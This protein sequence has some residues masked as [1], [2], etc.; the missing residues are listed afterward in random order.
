MEELFRHSL[1]YAIAKG[2]PEWFIDLRKEALTFY[3][4]ANW[5]IYERF[6][7]KEWDLTEVRL[8][9]MPV[10]QWPETPILTNEEN[11][12]LSVRVGNDSVAIQLDEEWSRKGV[13]VEDLWTALHDHE[14]LV[15]EAMYQLKEKDHKMHAQV[16]AYLTA[17]TFVYIPQNVILD[18]PIVLKTWMDNTRKHSLM[19]YL[20]VFVEEGAQIELFETLSSYGHHINLANVFTHLV[21]RDNTQVDFVSIDELGSQVTAYLSG[22]AEIGHNSQM[23]WTTAALSRGN[24]LGDYSLDALKEGGEG[25][26]EILS[27]A[28]GEQKK[29]FN[30]QTINDARHTIGHILQHAAV[31]DEAFLSFNGITSIDH[32]AKFSDGRQ[33]SRILMLSDKARGDVNPLLFIDQFEVTAGHSASAGQLDQEQLHYL[34]SRGIER[35]V[36]EQLV[37]RGFL[38]VVIERIR[39]RQLQNNIIEVVDERLIGHDE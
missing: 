35:R 4:T 6:P 3:Q 13:I 11:K 38:G 30:T 25:E 5:P 21:T 22:F 2:A 9:L 26:L 18:E 10:E 8:D 20:L 1:D 29:G 37:A 15:K 33:T 17:G 39:N 34:M 12:A 27:V 19:E 36:A 14:A 24:T 32:G 7:F 23:R 28:T 16:F 31:L